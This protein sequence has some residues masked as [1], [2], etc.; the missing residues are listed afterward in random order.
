[1]KLKLAVIALGLAGCSEVKNTTFTQSMKLG[2][3]D[4]DV[5]TLNAGAEAYMLYCRA[6]H[7]DTG[8]GDGPASAAL[9]PPPRDLRIAT[10]KFAGVVDGLPHDEDLARIIR[11]GLN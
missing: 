6:C 3:Q 7:G 9:R 11:G 10:Y 8:A 1:M 2:G 5:H 4:V